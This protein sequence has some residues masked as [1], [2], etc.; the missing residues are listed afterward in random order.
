MQATNNPFLEE[1]Y[2]L[3]AELETAL[4]ELE[5]NPKDADLVDRVFRA[6]HTIK[7]SGAMFGY[8]KIAEFTH[9]LETVFDL[10]REGK[11]PVSSELVNLSLTA[12]DH[13]KMLLDASVDGTAVDETQAAG[14]LDALGTFLPGTREPGREIESKR[15]VPPESADERADERVKTDSS[16]VTFRIRFKPDCSIF[17]NGTNPI[18]L[19]NELA[20]L[21]FCNIIAQTDS[22]PDIDNCDAEVCYIYWD[23]VLTTSKGIDSIKDVFI[24][25]EDSAELR[26]EVIEDGIDETEIDYK[27][28]GEILIE[29]G[30]LTDEDIAGAVRKQKR[31]GEILVESQA[32]DP[33]IIESALAEQAHVRL[34]RQKRQE[35]AAASSIRVPA[36]K[37]DVLVDLVGELVTVQARL[38]QKA[39]DASDGDLVNIS[40]VVE[41]LTAELRDNTLS[42]RMLPI[43]STFSKL[44]RLV[45]D[46]SR[47]LGKE[48]EMQTEGGETEL[49]KTV[50][51][52]LN[53]PLMHIIRNSIDHGIESPETRQ[54][55]GKPRQGM[56]Y[57]SAEHSGANV[58]IRIT[59][60][61]AGL[62]AE[63][64]RKKAAEKGLIGLDAELTEREIHSL[65]FAPGFSTAQTVSNVSGRGVGM[66]VVKRS[67]EALRGTVEV[68]SAP[69]EGTTITLKLPL[70]LAIIDG[71]LVEIEGDNY[72]LPLSSVEECVELTRQDAAKT[73]GRNILNIRGEIVPYVPLRE[74]FAI[75]GAPPDIEQ[76]V[77][78]QV[79]GQRVGIVVDRVIGEHQIV[80][81]TMSRLY[82]GVKEVS[83]ATILGDGTVALILELSRLLEVG[84]KEKQ[85]T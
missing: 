2:E 79:N 36:E 52:Q 10:V 58:L 9:Q 35:E 62:N 74:R 20:G 84:E 26:I 16:E 7:G 69:E 31:L 55:A 30:D 53:D 28:I 47:T 4:L 8:D 1:A 80:I 56:I 50:I 14:I 12:R 15:T 59:D 37:L 85:S 81:K 44:R 75:P 17:R 61:G 41:R 21:G 25:V 43:G 11:I 40:E 42:I 54:T 27:K 65:I 5:E 68:E 33:G 23:I 22:I 32:I 78:N 29:R 24:F 19:L 71:L 64:I 48:V 34:T 39:A 51:E 46:L 67:I 66:D 82:R 3:V 73:H 38:S 49:D 83:G 63:A 18:L 60:D 57:L 13:I 70:T 6:M 72:V 45:R 77:I 76:V